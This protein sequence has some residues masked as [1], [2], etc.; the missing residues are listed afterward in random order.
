VLIGGAVYSLSP[1]GVFVFT[2]VLTGLAGVL[3]TALP[4]RRHP[5]RDGSPVDDLQRAVRVLGSDGRLV[6]TLIFGAITFVL[7]RM[8][9]FA[10]QPHLEAH[11]AGVTGSQLALAAALL[12]GAKEIGGALLASASGGI[13]KRLGV[14]AIVITLAAFVVATYGVMSFGINSV[15]ILAMVLLGSAFGLFSPLMRALLNSLIP[16]PR[17]RATLLS[18]ESMGRRVLFAAASP[19]FGRAVEASSLH[20]AFAGTAWTALAAYGLLGA[21]TLYAVVPRLRA[22]VVASPTRTAHALAS[23]A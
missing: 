14:R 23:A 11:L 21:A 10:D 19:L 22:R 16:G 5:A 17:D 20:A 7:L 9:L 3:A 6:A 2:G 1:R 15:D 8:S 12:A 13:V 4:E 18:F